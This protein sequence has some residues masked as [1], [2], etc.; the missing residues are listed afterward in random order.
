MLAYR[1]F[2]SH[3]E[4]LDVLR[5]APVASGELGTNA[6][7]NPNLSTTGDGF[8]AVAIGDRF[9]ISG[10]TQEFIVQ[11]KAD[12]NNITLDSNIT[13]GHTAD[14]VW[15][16]FRGGIDVSTIVIGPV[17]SPV[18]S[19]SGIVVYEEVDFKV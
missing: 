5:G 1:T 13:A 12:A 16:A 8:A 17:F 11:A 10:D 19:G 3:K 18:Q 2:N 9:H 7:G 14:A 15:R 4:L 6:A